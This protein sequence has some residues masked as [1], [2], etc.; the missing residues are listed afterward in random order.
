MLTTFIGTAILGVTVTLVLVRPRLGRFQVD[1]ASAALFGA[2][3]TIAVGLVSFERVVEIVVFLAGPVITVVSMMVVTQVADRAGLLR[4]LA[5]SLAHHARGR[6]PRLFGLTFAST[7]LVGML[8]TNDA[9]I[10]IFTP[11]VVQLVESLGGTQWLL[12]QR[13]PFYFAVLYA[14]NLVGPLI[15]SNPI[16]LIV[17]GWFEIGFVDP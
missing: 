13:L 1:P 3:L 6:G 16:H 4:L 10:L 8:F 14:A 2:V 5:R 11:L 7:A 15:L 9:A 12:K 17:G